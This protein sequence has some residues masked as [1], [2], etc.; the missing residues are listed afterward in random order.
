VT[1][2]VQTLR[3]SVKRQRPVEGTQQV[4][5]LYVNFADYQFG[6]I[7]PSKIPL[8]LIAIRFFSAATD[9]SVGDFVVNAGTLYRANTAVAAGPFTPS[10]WTRSVSTIDLALKEDVIAPGTV[11]QYWRGDKTW[12]TLDKAAVG[13]PNVDNTA[14]L[15]K[16]TSAATQAKLDL[17][18]DRAG[19]TMSGHLGLPVTPNANQAVRRD[20]VDSAV[21]TLNAAIAL[22]APIANA[23]LTGNPTA[24]T[25]LQGDNDTSIAT[26]AFVTRAVFVGTQGFVYEA[27]IDGVQYVR[28]DAT[29]QPV[30]VPEETFIGDNPPIGAKPGQ[31]WYESDSGDT[32]LYVDDGTSYQWVQINGGAAVTPGS[33]EPGQVAWFAMGMPPFGWLKA[34]GA[35]ISRTAYASLFAAIGVKHGIGNGSTTFNIPDLRGE[36]IRG[37]DDGREVDT[38]RLIGTHQAANIQSHTHTASGGNHTHTASSGTDSA[39]HYHGVNGNTGYVSVD[40]THG[41][42]LPGAQSTNAG[43]AFLVAPHNINLGFNTGGISANHYHGV[44]INS[45]NVSNWHTHAITV[46]SADVTPTI[47][48]AGTGVDTRPRNVALLGCIRYA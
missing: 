5:A 34:N 17:K 27:P 24:P 9:Y 25:P 4:G 26:T 47:A 11:S 38:G 48:A 37:L 2:R 36:F 16:P 20:F 41:I 44:G 7:N 31:I 40:H 23:A 28:S 12:Q 42:T 18:V 6:T 10:Q 19:D 30:V 46:D 15:S 39:N 3:S 45:G 14:D 1:D 35:A 13:L 43:S 21:I 8:D 33:A 32:F 22:K 29:W